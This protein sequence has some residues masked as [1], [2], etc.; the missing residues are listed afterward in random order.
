MDFIQEV[1]KRAKEEGR[2]SPDLLP[3]EG[4]GPVTEKK[5]TRKKVHSTR[6]S[7]RRT[8]HKLQIPKELYADC[9]KLS[10]NI[11]SLAHDK[12]LQIIGFTSAV[13][14]E[15][16]STLI[17]IT[18][19]LFAEHQV[20]SFENTESL[21]NELINKSSN[22]YSDSENIIV[23]DASL[24]NPRLHQYFGVA[25]TP[26]LYE[27]LTT[28][29]ALEKVLREIYTTSTEITL[30]PAGLRDEKSPKKCN[31]EKINQLLQRLRG[32]FNF[33]FIDIPSLLHNAESLLLSK[34]CDAVVLIVRA[35]FTRLEIIQEA[36]KCL[37][38]NKIQ[39]L[40]SVLN[41]RKYYVPEGIYKRL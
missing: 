16:T 15:G 28:R 9:H 10:E 2:I 1:L 17:S 18:T 23:I 14:Q 21:Q 6:R 20:G 38:E 37:E 8:L 12:S 39:V 36:K 41:R 30:L 31:P 35:G 19:S 4:T 13:P 24:R 25:L 32:Q 3:W 7:V 29:I 26:G 11:Y 5:C 34:L 33:I 40:G 27:Q 22:R